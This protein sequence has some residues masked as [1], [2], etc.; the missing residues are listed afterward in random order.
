MRQQIAK[1]PSLLGKVMMGL[2]YS[3]YLKMLASE[4]YLLFQFKEKNAAEWRVLSKFFDDE[5]GQ[6]ISSQGRVFLAI[7]D[8][9]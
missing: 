3:N 2:K 5:M 4:L 7:L 1:N 6:K 8:L 9:E